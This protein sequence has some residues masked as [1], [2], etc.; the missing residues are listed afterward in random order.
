ME[1]AVELG[2]AIK[3]K[4]DINGWCRLDDTSSSDYLY[5]LS[6]INEIFATGIPDV[7]SSDGRQKSE[8]NGISPRIRPLCLVSGH[9]I[10]PAVVLP[11]VF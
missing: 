2:V 9:L 7:G 6:C 3:G 1:L 11:N 10:C 4:R 5:C 8:N